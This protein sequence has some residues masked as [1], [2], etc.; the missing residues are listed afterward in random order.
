VIPRAVLEINHGTCRSAT[1]EIQ[2]LELATMAIA[3]MVLL[4]ILYYIR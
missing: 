1:H 4:S 2:I 3:G